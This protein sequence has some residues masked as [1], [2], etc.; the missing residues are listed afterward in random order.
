MSIV[1]L[2]LAVFLSGPAPVQDSPSVEQL[3]LSGDVACEAKARETAR[4]ATLDWET[5][6]GIVKKV[7]DV[8]QRSLCRQQVLAVL[9]AFPRV[10]ALELL[11]RYSRED[12]D[13]LVRHLAQTAAALL[14]QNHPA[15]S[16][17]TIR[18]AYES[19]DPAKRSL[20]LLLHI[21]SGADFPIAEAGFLIPRDVVTPQESARVEG[22]VL[23]QGKTHTLRL[24]L[25][26]GLFDG[27][28]FDFRAEVKFGTPEGDKRRVTGRWNVQIEGDSLRLAVLPEGGRP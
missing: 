20:V 11:E 24:P 6:S 12:K 27:L 14:I 26:Y 23:H 18:A 8:E 16:G 10:E 1:W 13:S 9:T 21:D 19:F 3:L 5:A 4:L 15:L 17:V 28:E 2:V 25:K 22:L 7:L